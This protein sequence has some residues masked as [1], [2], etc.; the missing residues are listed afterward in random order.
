MKR[1]S[2]GKIQIEFQSTFDGS[3]KKKP[4]AQ[5][6]QTQK[7]SPPIKLDVPAVLDSPK[8]AT[9]Q[10]KSKKDDSES[11]GEGID[12]AKMS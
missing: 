8:A 1:F 6:K 5:K 4:V 12:E 10:K 9:P 11:E 3:R 2:E 7:E